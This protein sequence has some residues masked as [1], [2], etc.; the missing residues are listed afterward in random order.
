MKRLWTHLLILTVMAAGTVSRGADE[1]SPDRCERQPDR[2][3]DVQTMQAWCDRYVEAAKAGDLDTYRTFWSKDVIWLPPGEPMI[4]GIEACMEHHRPAF[5]QL[6]Q[7]ESVRVRE[8]TSC[9]ASAIMRVDYTYE[10]IPKPDSTLKP[11]HE[12]GKGIFVMRRAAGGEWV[13]THCVWNLDSKPNE[14]QR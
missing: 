8:V 5:E 14:T 11:V 13:A 3:A 1:S 10:G 12:V 7:D 4:Q 9:G 2:Q 6:K